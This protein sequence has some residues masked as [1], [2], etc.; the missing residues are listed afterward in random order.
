M[1]I[2]GV[3]RQSFFTVDTGDRRSELRSCGTV[4][5]MDLKRQADL[6]AF[7]QSRLGER[8]QDLIAYDSELPC[9]V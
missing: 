2:D 9:D 6:S 5:V 8:D 1:N 7:V 3:F 4:G